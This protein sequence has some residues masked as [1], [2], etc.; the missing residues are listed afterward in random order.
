MPVLL[1]LGVFDMMVGTVLVLSPFV[2]LE[3]NGFVLAL[4]A[5][6]LLKGLYSYIAAAAA[7]FY[8]DLLGILDITVGTCLVF[9]AYSIVSGVFPWI[10]IFM[11][12]KGLYSVIIFMIR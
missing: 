5:I 1:M 12:A 7:G 10:G 2:S 9:A 6:A 3:G 4:G 11:V 8:F